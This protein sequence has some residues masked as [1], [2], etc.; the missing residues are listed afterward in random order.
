MSRW[1]PNARAASSRQPWSST[2]SA[3]SNRPRSRRSPG[4][5]GSRSGRSSA[6]R[7]QARGAVRGR[8]PARGLRRDP[9]GRRTPDRQRRST[10]SPRASRPPASV[11]GAPRTRPQAAGRH[12]RERGLAG[13][14]ADQGHGRL[15]DR[16]S[17]APT[18]RLRAGREPD[19]QGGHPV[20]KVAFERW[21]ADGA[22]RELS[23]VIGES[24][25]ELKTVAGGGGDAAGRPAGSLARRRVADASSLRGITFARWR[26]STGRR[27]G[28]FG[29]F[30]EY[31]PPEAAHWLAAGVEAAYEPP[32]AC[33]R[34]HPD[35]RHRARRRPDR[36]P[37]CWPAF[38]APA[39]PR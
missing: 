28:E 23:T 34:P 27:L 33:T 12:R 24:V 38:R 19:G 37:R 20:F 31:E 4:V 21:V 36:C 2:A 25:D 13:T 39:P 35:Q 11:P 15:G 32:P 5:R 3:G 30:L 26:C 16:R 17:A 7:R 22:D 10:R 14:R 1:E 6:L 29:A 9:L 8:G 18:R